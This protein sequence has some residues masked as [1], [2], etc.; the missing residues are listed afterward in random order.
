MGELKKT[1]ADVLDF[2]KVG[3]I[4]KANKLRLEIIKEY[5]TSKFAKILK[6]RNKILEEEKGT[7]KKLDSL[8]S[9]FSE[10][11]FEEVLIGIEKQ[12]AFIENKE[13]LIDFELLRAQTMG[14]LEGVLKYKEE[15][16][17]ITQNTNFI[18]KF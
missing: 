15:L 16:K 3:S 8:N 11:K 18:N 13:I 4:I 1:H 9:F 7:L 2:S 12:V 17:N 10:Q 5:P 14:K 6:D